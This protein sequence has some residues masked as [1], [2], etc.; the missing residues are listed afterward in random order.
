MWTKK[1]KWILLLTLL[2]FSCEKESEG[3]NDA[4]LG[5]TDL[6]AMNYNPEATEEDYQIQY[7]HQV[8]SV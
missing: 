4:T 1:H 7:N 5:C 2:I 8:D 3:H 6:T